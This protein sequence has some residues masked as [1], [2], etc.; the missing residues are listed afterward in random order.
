MRPITRRSSKGYLWRPHTPVCGVETHLERNRASARVPTRHA[1]VRAPH[2]PSE[3]C[4]HIDDHLGPRAV[5][6]Y[7]AID[8]ASAIVGRQRDQLT[9]HHHRKGLHLSFPTRWQ[10]AGTIELLLQAG[11]QRTALT[12]VVIVDD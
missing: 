1:G 8:K 11:R 10:P 4:G 12:P 9:L 7:L 5:H 6:H 3:H 2:L